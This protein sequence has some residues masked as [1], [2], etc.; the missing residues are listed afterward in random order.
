[1]RVYRAWSGQFVEIDMQECHSCHCWYPD[2]ELR[3]GICDDCREDAVRL[4]QKLCPHKQAVIKKD[5][6]ETEVKS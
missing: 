2:G 3:G 5:L 4:G 6:S 1:M